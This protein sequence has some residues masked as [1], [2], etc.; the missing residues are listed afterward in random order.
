MLFSIHQQKQS[1]DTQLS[2]TDGP[3]VCYLDLIKIDFLKNNYIDFEF[4]QL[5]GY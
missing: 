2:I 4:S 5:D 1:L 3:A